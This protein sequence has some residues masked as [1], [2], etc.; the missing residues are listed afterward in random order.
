MAFKKTKMTSPEFQEAYKRLIH[1]AYQII[2]PYLDQFENIEGNI[3]SCND[4]IP[5][6]YNLF[7]AAREAKSGRV[8]EIGFNAGFSTIIMLLANPAVHVTAID[9]CTH[10]N[11]KWCANLVQELFPNRLTFIEGDSQR[12]FP[13]TGTYDLVHIDGDHSIEG[14]TC[15]FRNSLS[16]RGAIVILDDTDIPHIAQLWQDAVSKGKIHNA[17]SGTYIATPFHSIGQVV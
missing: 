14:A 6:I 7:T 10:P 4:Y 17:S 12:V 9:I 11:V 13:H 8:L 5:K 16:L 15:D 1:I 3:L 2:K